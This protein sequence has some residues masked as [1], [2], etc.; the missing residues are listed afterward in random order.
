MRNSKENTVT[1]EIAVSATILFNSVN[2]QNHKT[3][4]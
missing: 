2:P 3:L 4:L 1:L